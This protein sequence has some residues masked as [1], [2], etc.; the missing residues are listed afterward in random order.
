MNKVTKI[1]IFTFGSL[2]LGYVLIWVG[3]AVY[4]GW[5]G[6]QWEKKTEKFQMMLSKPYREDVYGGKTP[7]ETWALFLDALR[8]G[9]VELASK[10]FVPE[11]QIEWKE[12]I[13][14]TANDS[15]KFDMAI[16]NIKS[17][18]LETSTS[19]TAYFIYPVKDEMGNTVLNSLVFILNP[20]TKVWKISVL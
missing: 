10:Y 16:N 17:I 1:I 4:S 8:K 7:E 5:T 13:R 9:D 12:A 18:T 3:Y 15:N 11:K 20:Y 14:K 6:Y 19:E 2:V